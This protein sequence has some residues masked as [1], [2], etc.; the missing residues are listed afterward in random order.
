MAPEWWNQDMNPGSWVS[1]QHWAEQTES[2]ESVPLALTVAMVLMQPQE[3]GA[4]SM[5][6]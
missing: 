4:H 3:P 6:R 2:A 5:C 1:G